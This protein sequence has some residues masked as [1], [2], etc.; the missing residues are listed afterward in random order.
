MAFSKRSII[1]NL[2]IIAVTVIL[3]LLGSVMSMGWARIEKLED[4]LHVAENSRPLSEYILN[5]VSTQNDTQTKVWEIKIQNV[6]DRLTRM[7]ERL[8]AALKTSQDDIKAL[9]RGQ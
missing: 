9:I 3:A 5:I 7:E 4:R 2:P 1:E 6:H 8:T